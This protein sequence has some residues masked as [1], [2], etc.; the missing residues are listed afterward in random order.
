MDPF[1][2]IALPIVQ[3]YAATASESPGVR[4]RRTMGFGDTS[5]NTSFKN[6]ECIGGSRSAAYNDSG[7]DLLPTT[8]N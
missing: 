3:L 6:V 1:C 5:V 7:I 8:L 4:G 2:A